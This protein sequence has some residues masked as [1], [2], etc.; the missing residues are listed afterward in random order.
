MG[1]CSTWGR[2]VHGGNFEGWRPSERTWNHALNP[3]SRGHTKAWE[4]FAR[5]AN[6]LLDPQ[7]VPSPN[8]RYEPDSTVVA[9]GAGR[10]FGVYPPKMAKLWP[11]LAVF[12]PMFA[13]KSWE[14]RW[15]TE[16]EARGEKHIAL[17]SSDLRCWASDSPK[18]HRL[19]TPTLQC[20]HLS[21][22]S[23]TRRGFFDFEVGGHDGAYK[24]RVHVIVP[25]VGPKN[26]S[27]A[28]SHTMCLCSGFLG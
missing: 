24:G 11:E 5:R 18:P 4:N 12:G 13:L 25:F 2:V 6:V 26:G 22:P 23:R 10:C 14:H 15:I 16:Q 19:W 3:N 9:L 27:H 21:G 8:P 20:G 28:N 7:G 1:C 17:H